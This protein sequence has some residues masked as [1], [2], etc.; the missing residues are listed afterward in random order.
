MKT[1]LNYESCDKVV[2]FSYRLS[3]IAHHFGET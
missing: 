1:E 3:L 2:I